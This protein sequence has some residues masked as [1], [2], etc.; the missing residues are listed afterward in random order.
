TG[1]ARAGP[2]FELALEGR[3]PRLERLELL[4]CALE[5]GALHV[6]FL[7]RDEVHALETGVYERA[8]VALQIVAERAEILR[9][10]LRELPREVVQSETVRGIGHRKILRAAAA[11]GQSCGIHPIR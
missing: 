5:H 11:T 6:E 8:R 1:V 2:P 7:A 4:A 10:R 3:E 9:K